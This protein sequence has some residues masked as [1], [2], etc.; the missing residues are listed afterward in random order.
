MENSSVQGEFIITCQHKLPKEEREEPDGGMKEVHVVIKQS[1]FIV[2]IASQTKNLEG[3][4]VECTLVYDTP[5]LNVC[6]SMKSNTTY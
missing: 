1:S 2:M 3:C 5:T 4:S 6:L